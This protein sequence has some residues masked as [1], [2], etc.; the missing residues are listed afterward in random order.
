VPA[1]LRFDRPEL[2][3]GALV[4]RAV[5]GPT[6]ERRRHSDHVPLAYLYEVVSR[7]DPDQDVVM[8]AGHYDEAAMV[9]RFSGDLAGITGITEPLSGT[10]NC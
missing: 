4:I 3:D 6:R 9:W 5:P 8:T 2:T 7:D 1:F 10:P